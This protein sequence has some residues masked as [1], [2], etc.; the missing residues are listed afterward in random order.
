[1]NMAEE[2]KKNRLEIEYCTGCR[3]LM[4]AAWMAQEFLTTFQ[5]SL[6]EVALQPGKG[7]VYE[8]RLNG[9]TLFS[10]KEHGGFRDIKELKQLI[11]DGIDPEMSLGHSDKKTGQ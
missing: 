9:A 11:R 5:E 6:H 2:E 4:R 7:G 8:I 1:M 3:W 10:R